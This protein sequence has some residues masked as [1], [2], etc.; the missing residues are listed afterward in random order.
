MI[1]GPNPPPRKGA[2]TRTWLSESPSIAASPL[3]IGIG[4]WVVSQISRRAAFG[5]QLATTPRFSIAAAV[6]RS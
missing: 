5:S 1:F 6:P 2:T 3:R 4:A